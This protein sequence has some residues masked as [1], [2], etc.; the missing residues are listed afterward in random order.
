M[1]LSWTL[2]GVEIPALGKYVPIWYFSRRLVLTLR[3]PLQA[4]VTA[5][6]QRS[7]LAPRSTAMGACP[8]LSWAAPEIGQNTT[9]RSQPVHST[10]LNLQA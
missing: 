8:G 2:H 9:N 10:A 4:D 1:I 7:S 5:T 6:T 3:R